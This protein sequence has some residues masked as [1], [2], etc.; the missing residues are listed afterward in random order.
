[1]VREKLVS[2]LL[3]RGGVLV[4]P[5]VRAVHVH[6]ERERGMRWGDACAA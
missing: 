1:M 6:W 2:L 4:G 3:P 5:M